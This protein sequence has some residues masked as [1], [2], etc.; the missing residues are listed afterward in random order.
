VRDHVL[1]GLRGGVYGI[2]SRFRP[3]LVDVEPARAGRRLA[4]H[5]VREARLREFGPVTF[6]SYPGANVAL[7]AG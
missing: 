7:A 3:T 4:R 6:P 2:S 1:P 5:S